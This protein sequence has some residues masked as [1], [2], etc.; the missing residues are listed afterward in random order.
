VKRRQFIAGLGSA[1]AWPVVAWAQQGEPMRRVGVLVA[2]DAV[3]H[4]RFEALK[5]RLAELGWVEGRNVHFDLRLSDSNTEH[6][7]AAAAELVGS[8]PQA[9]V[10]VSPG[11]RPLRELTHA[12]PVVFV[13]AL[14]PVAEGFVASL[15]KPGGN[16]TGFAGFDPAFSGKYLQLLKEAAPHIRHA[17][18]I[19]DPI[20]TGITRFPSAAAASASL[21]GLDFTSMPVRDATE[22]ERAIEEFARKP[23]GA[24]WVP[25]NTAI[26]ANLELVISLTRRHRI[27]TIGVFRFFADRGGLMSYGPDDLDMFRGAASYVDRILKNEKPADLAVQYPSKYQ[28]VVNR[29]AAEAIGLELPTPLLSV[30][31]E[32][33]E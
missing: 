19:Y 20:V 9:I 15:A 31:D 28:F 7:R 22:I 27:P 6:V 24:M 10:T 3:G 21:L 13:L 18:F 12:I 26:N 4:A 17:A 5:L 8:A 32:L 2:G 11:L 16:M 14:D 23:D 30:A 1:A 25:S 33:V 29:S